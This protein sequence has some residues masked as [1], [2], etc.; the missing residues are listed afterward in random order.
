MAIVKATYTR[1]KRAAKASVRY[2][3]HRPGEQGKRTTREIYGIDG[4]LNKKDAYRMIDTANKG[5]VFFRLVISPDPNEEDKLRDL[6]LTQLAEATM[7]AMEKMLRKEVPFI[8]VDHTDH[9][10]K[11]HI[12][13]IAC[14]TGKLTPRHFQALRE[15]ATRAARTQRQERDLARQARQQAVEEAQWV[16]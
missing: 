3:T 10:D 9:T 11:R 6:H 13:V 8:A 2:I 15:S 1:N 12:H 14:V 16:I 5:S 4:R 7:L